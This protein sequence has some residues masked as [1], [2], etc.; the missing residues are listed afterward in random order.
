MQAFEESAL[1]VHSSLLGQPWRWRRGDPRAAEQIAQVHGVPEIVA[2]LLANRDV[3]FEDAP[4]VLLPTLRRWL[5]NPSLFQDMDNAVE[6]IIHALN[7]KQRITIFGDYDVDG[8]TSSALLIRYFRKIGVQAGVYIPDRIKEGYGPNSVAMRKLA[9]DGTQLIITVDCGTQSFEPLAEAQAAGVDVI[10]VDHHKASTTLPVAA[11]IINPNRF[12]EHIDASA[13]GHLAAV[14]V[15]FLLCV[16]LNRALRGTHFGEVDLLDLLDVV[17][18]GTVCDV[19]PLTGLNRA[20]VTQGLKVMARRQQLGL[21]TLMDISGLSKAPDAGALGFYL[22]PRI[23]AGG[24]VGQSDLGVRLLT[25]QDENEARHLA[26]QLD[27]FNSERKAI[28][29]SVQQDASAMAERQDSAIILVANDGWH[30][31]VIGIVAGRIKEQMGRP[32]LVVALDG[33]TGKGSGR[34]ISGVDLGAAVLAAKADGLLINGGGHAM[35]A[36]VTV[37]RDQLEPLHAYLEAQMAEDINRAQAGKALWLDGALAP[38]GM[39]GDLARAVA[40]A[41]P[42]GSGWAAPRI[43]VGP[44]KIIRCDVV[45]ENH[46]RAIV[47]GQDGGKLKAMAFRSADTPLGDALLHGEGRSFWLAGRISHDDWNGKDDAELHIED[48]AYVSNS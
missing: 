43:A 38:A 36:G 5:P 2:R 7:T 28:E 25:T 47:T 42:F 17:A 21:T 45:G 20:F 37:A 22:G 15:A 24:R 33:D 9:A 4:D 39:T 48:A 11:A 34:S 16:A 1:G 30:P 6:R 32:A 10:V 35:A 31:G 46:V 40:G 27:D 23:N 19:V 29:A 44:A 14:G 8:A 13:H 41:G 12:D 26:R 18:L 3:S